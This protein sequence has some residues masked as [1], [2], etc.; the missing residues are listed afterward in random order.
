MTPWVLIADCNGTCR[1]FGYKTESRQCLHE[2]CT[3][4]VTSFYVG[5][6]ETRSVQCNETEYNCTGKL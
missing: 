2:G 6:N 1:D 5:E 4:N 3:N